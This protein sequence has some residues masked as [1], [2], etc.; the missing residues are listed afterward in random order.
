MFTLPYNITLLPLPA[1]ST[2]KLNDKH[3]QR[4]ELEEN[5]HSFNP[6]PNKPLTKVTTFFKS[7]NGPSNSE[8]VDTFS[9]LLQCIIMY[10]CMYYYHYY[11]YYYYHF[12]I[13]IIILLL[14]LYYYYYYYYYRRCRFYHCHVSIIIIITIFIL[15]APFHTK[16]HEVHVDGGRGHTKISIS[17]YTISVYWRHQKLPYHFEQA[18]LIHIPCKKLSLLL[19]KI[20]LK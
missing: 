17:Y 11:Y 12:I 8:C 6:P 20:G 5:A 9:S 13:I 18:L 10:V 16:N 7:A 19:T 15:C 4:V 2:P 3:S 1:N 14:L